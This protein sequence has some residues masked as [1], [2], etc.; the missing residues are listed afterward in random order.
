MEDW[1]QSRIKEALYPKS[2]AVLG[3]S[4][5]ANNLGNQ[6]VDVLMLEGFPGPIYPVHPRLKG[7]SGLPV[8]SSLEA[9]GKPVDLVVCSLNAK[10]TTEYVIESCAKIG[11]KGI[12]CFAGGFKEVGGEGLRYEKRL[13]EV[14]DANHIIIFGPNILGVI[15]NETRLYALFWSFKR[16]NPL[17]PVSIVSQ[18]GGTACTM[19]NEFIDRRVGVNK[20]VCLGNRVNL[21]FSDMF[22]YFADDEGTGAVAAFIEGIEDGRTFMD[23]A[24]VLAMKKPLVVLKGARAKVTSVMASSH[25]GTMGG[26]YPIFKDACRQYKILNVGNSRDLVTVCK[27]LAIAPRPCGDRV[28]VVTHTAGPS[29]L[30]L[31]TLVENGC[32]IAQTSEETRRK[33]KKIIGEHIP[34]VLAP[35]PIDLTGSGLFVDIYPRCV[36]AVIE[37]DGVD[38]VIPI[39]AIH[40]NF[41]TSARALAELK[42]RTPK[43]IIACL[44]ASRDEIVEDEKIMQEAGIP[45]FQTPE[46]A[47]L[48]ATY[49]AKYYH[50]TARK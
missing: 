3:V 46:D 44:L 13:K 40:R 47:A 28:A 49:L 32:P 30:A 35:N 36:E 41:E 34:I 9:I 27:A 42:R 38:M 2:V 1:K 43:P 33:I 39:Y 23:A 37:D 5:S 24:R 8:Y 18:S 20:M 48:A 25:T 16:G 29:I 22:R 10:L 26:T 4:E 19:F 12:V 21:E 17:G 50:Y 6:V 15:N 14:A 7:L 45:V 31:D 11:V